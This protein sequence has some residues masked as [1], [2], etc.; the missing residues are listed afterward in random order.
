VSTFD[1]LKEKISYLNQN[2]QK[3]I[4]KAYFFA[5]ENHQNQKRNT[6]EPYI[7]HSLSAAATIAD[8]KL[9]EP[10]VAA[11]LLH[12]ICEDTVITPAQLRK[13]FGKEISNIVDG[14]TKLSKIRIT[15]R[16]L[17]V[18]EK[19]QLADYDR[20]VET[21]R[22]MFMAMAQ[23]IRVV[24]IKLADR[25]HNMQT[26]DGVP[27]TKRYRIAK[28]TLIIYAPIANRLGMGE[29]RG[30]L[31]DLSFPI[32]YPKEYMELKKQVANRLSEKEKYITK[33]KKTIMI[34][35]YK[36][37]VRGEIHGR[38]KH[39]YSLWRKLQRYDNDL[40]SIYDLVA[41]RI[42]VNTIEECYKTL[43]IIHKN[44]KPL[45]GRIKDYI[46]MPK[47]NG[48]RSIHTTVFGP[49]GEIVEIQIRT[50]EMHQQA[51][52]GIAA[53]WHYSEKKGGIDYI[54][55][56]NSRV[57]KEELVWVKELANWQKALADN[58]E[59]ISTLGMDFFSKR[60][61]VYTP[62]GDVKNLPVGA[63]PIDFAYAV[64]TDL[65]NHTGGAKVNNKMVDFSHQLQSGDIVEII[66]KK[67]ASPK[68]DWLEYAKTSL[69]RAKI[70]SQTKNL[71]K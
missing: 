5:E 11:A 34:K 23:D 42:I 35:L 30:Q 32:V 59:M 66:K 24:I 43:G 70:K 52:F 54:L 50:K 28:E 69:A 29:L 22:K 7:Q 48:Y 3:L 38:T 57:P 68:T 53:H 12:D 27:E 18:K 2:D 17:F 31:E 39:M 65:G 13:E 8:L 1:E 16:W 45:V 60:I 56:K 21:L 64:H 33:L 4:E 71:K 49:G 9:D 41:L 47:P 55:R 19:E 14:V 67:N 36:E 25:L 58:K 44:W 20:Q 15:T 51:E 46:A 40:S 62:T 26:I 10:S 63:T 6:G 61:F 37:G